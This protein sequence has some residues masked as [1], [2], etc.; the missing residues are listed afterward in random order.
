MA[1]LSTGDLPFLAGPP[2]EWSALQAVDAVIRGLAG[3]PALAP[4]ESKIGVYL[5]TKENAPENP[6]NAEGP[7]DRWAVEQ[8]DF[9]TP[10]SE[11]WGVDLS[12]IAANSK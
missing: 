7:V 9:V 1:G 8:F 11:A 4:E 6:G 2:Q 10:Y 12:S 5:M 3:K